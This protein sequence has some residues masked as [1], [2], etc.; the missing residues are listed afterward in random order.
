MT[1]LMTT[2]DD[3][4]PLDGL[5]EPAKKAYLRGYNLAFPYGFR[6]VRLPARTRTS[7]SGWWWCGAWASSP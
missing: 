5:S 4:D 3:E 6:P 2:P 1:T 7:P